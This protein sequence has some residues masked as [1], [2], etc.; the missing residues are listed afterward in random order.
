MF[1]AMKQFIHS[2]DFGSS[3][4]INQQV[5]GR[6]TIS[7]LKRSHVDQSLPSGVIPILGPR[8]PRSPVLWHVLSK[9]TLVISQTFIHNLNMDVRLGVVASTHLQRST[10]QIEEL[11]PKCT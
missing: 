5:R 9:T 6:N 7:R 8:K 2:M 10:L 11:L 1:S 4:N 3:R